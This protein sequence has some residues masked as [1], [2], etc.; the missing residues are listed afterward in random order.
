M[1]HINTTPIAMAMMDY[2]TWF[3]PYHYKPGYTA[4]PQA[5][6]AVP[7]DTRSRMTWVPYYEKDEVDP[8]GGGIFEQIC[9]NHYKVGVVNPDD[10]EDG[11]GTD[12]EVEL[13]DLPIGFCEVDPTFGTKGD[14][15][16]HTIENS[17]HWGGDCA[18]PF[19]NMYLAVLERHF[20]CSRKDIPHIDIID[21][22][23]AYGKTDIAKGRAAG[24]TYNSN[25]KRIFWHTKI[26][27]DKII[28]QYSPNAPSRVLFNVLFCRRQCVPVV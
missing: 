5:V 12:E 8:E 1:N 4:Y 17:Y 24:F 3:Y 28:N 2:K 20:G 19:Q 15:W 7:G 10:F 9:P 25:T 22:A 11:A 23:I 27:R 14:E 13:D 18:K 6:F 21:H 26:Y 16:C